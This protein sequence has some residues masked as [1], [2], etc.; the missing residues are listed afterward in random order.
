MNY[1]LY[2]II[3]YSLANHIYINI[4]LFTNKWQK[5]SNCLQAHK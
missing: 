4:E 2:I 3:H 5:P 1:I